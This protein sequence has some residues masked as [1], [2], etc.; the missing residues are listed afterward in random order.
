MVVARGG[1][2]SKLFTIINAAFFNTGSG[3]HAD[4]HTILTIERTCMGG[5]S[6]SELQ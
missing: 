4:M 5:D 3:G 1:K 2:S 6:T